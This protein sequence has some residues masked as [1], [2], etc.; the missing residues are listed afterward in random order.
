M[1]AVRVYARPHQPATN[2]IVDSGRPF[3]PR[4][5]R[6]PGN[7]LVPVDCC[8]RLHPAKNVTVEVTYDGAVGMLFSCRPRKGCKLQS[9]RKR[10]TDRKL[11]SEFQRGLS[12]VGLA[13]KYGMTSRE[14]QA[15]V[16][17]TP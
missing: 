11:L 3:G 10:V 17:R 12:F 6:N 15:R 8:E 4:R 7:R 13:R 5:F 2:Y 16:R 9:R 14:V 1:S